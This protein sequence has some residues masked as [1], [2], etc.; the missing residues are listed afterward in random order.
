MKKS[1]YTD[2]QGKGRS[3]V[4]DGHE[5]GRGYSESRTQGNQEAGGAGYVGRGSST[6]QNSLHLPDSTFST[7]L[8][9]ASTVSHQS[10]T[11]PSLCQSGFAFNRM[12]M[13]CEGRQLG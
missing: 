8:N 7:F 5:N 10:S 1:Y 4:K 12:T 3:T 9:P 13:T 11:S 6:S 2:I